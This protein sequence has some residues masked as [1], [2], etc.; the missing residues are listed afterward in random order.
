[1]VDHCTV[2][3]GRKAVKTDSRTLRLAR[4]LSATLPGPHYARDWTKGIKSWGMMVNDRL[5]DCTIAACGHAVQIWSLNAGGEITVPD[6]A[7]LR[8][9]GVWDGYVDGDPSTDNGG[10][11]ID[12]LNDWRQQTGGC[13]AT[14]PLLGYASV[15]VANL[16][17]VRQ[18]IELFGGVY[19]GISLPITAQGQSIWDVVPDDGSGNSAPG[20]WGGHAVFV[21]AYNHFK[22]TF[23]CITWGMLQTMT[24][25]FWEK[26]VDESYALLGKNWLT[27]KGSPLG[28][29]LAQLQTDLGL[30]R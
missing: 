19:I 15:N 1:M 6:S 7:I 27:A 4:Y 30:I 14:T 20:S 28:F 9:Y 13:F 26:Y 22:S 3:L 18:A 8:A 21:P 24:Y 11:E 16:K 17:E 12:V 29:N 25:A 23:E 5:G 2:K 10:I